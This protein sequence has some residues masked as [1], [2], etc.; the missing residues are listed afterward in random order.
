[1]ES[2][3]EQRMQND[4]T[5]K[6]LHE[7]FLNSANKIHNP[8]KTFLMRKEEGAWKE[9]SYAYLIEEIN[10]MASF[11]IESGLEK[12][13]RVAIV[14]ENCP[15]Y[16]IMD[17]ALQKIGLVNVSIY[18]TLTPEETKFIINDSGSKMVA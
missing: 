4:P 17:Q 16:Y 5:F 9:Y 1:M 15:E 6:S 2:L 11:F 10:K 14:L 13:D 12:G 3:A 18:P 7:F 8:Q